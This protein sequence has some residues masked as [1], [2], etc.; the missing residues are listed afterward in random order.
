[1]GKGRFLAALLAG[2]GVGIGLTLLLAPQSGEDTREWIAVVS[3]RAGRRL[4]DTGR[5]SMDQVR[6]VLERGQEG[7]TR[8]VRNR[9]NGREDEATEY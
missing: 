1:M 4:R 3:R 8:V 6:D 5:R 7:V 2:L 9:G